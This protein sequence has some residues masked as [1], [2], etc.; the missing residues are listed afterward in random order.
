[1][2]DASAARGREISS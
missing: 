2:F 1:M